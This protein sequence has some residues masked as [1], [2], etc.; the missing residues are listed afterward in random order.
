MEKLC[1][2]AQPVGSVQCVHHIIWIWQS[3]SLHLQ[4]HYILSRYLVHV[5]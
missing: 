4:V 5:L 2:F 1:N 3:S